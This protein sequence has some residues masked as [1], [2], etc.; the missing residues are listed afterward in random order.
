MLTG[1]RTGQLYLG[2]LEKTELTVD[3]I[4]FYTDLTQTDS[5]QLHQN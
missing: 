4:G 3:E 1:D 2:T 5:I